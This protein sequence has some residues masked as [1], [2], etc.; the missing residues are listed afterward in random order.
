MF[1]WLNTKKARRKMS[2]WSLLCYI[3]LIRQWSLT[4]A[5]NTWWRSERSF[6]FLFWQLA[7]WPKKIWACTCGKLELSGVWVFLSAPQCPVPLK[8][9]SSSDQ[10]PLSFC[11]GLQIFSSHS[12]LCPAG[13]Q[14]FCTGHR[15]ERRHS[16]HLIAQHKWLSWF[17]EI[18]QKFPR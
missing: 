2:R 4:V 5:P 1:W 15:A 6:Y 3:W 16:L 12:K 8:N 17:L 18:D 7:E 10:V 14:D 11:S 9:L 13:E